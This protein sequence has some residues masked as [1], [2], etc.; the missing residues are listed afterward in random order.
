MDSLI[1]ACG[2]VFIAIISLFA[3]LLMAY[4]AWWCVV[5][6][7]HL[8]T[9]SFVARRRIA[10][11]VGLSDWVKYYLIVI[12]RPFQC[13][14]TKINGVNYHIDYTGFIPK[15]KIFKVDEKEPRAF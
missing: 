5:I 8:V 6:P 13:Q 11:D 9:V 14:N 10:K 4:V 12:K 2:V 7:A 1:F 3:L 15:T